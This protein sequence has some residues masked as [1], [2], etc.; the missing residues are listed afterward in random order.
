MLREKIVTEK[1]KNDYQLIWKKFFIFLQIE[2]I[3][4]EKL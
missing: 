3:I 2:K 1:L 4:S